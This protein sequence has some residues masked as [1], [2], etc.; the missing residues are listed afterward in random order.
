M[1]AHD[2]G[3]HAGCTRRVVWIDTLPL[4]ALRLSDE[5]VHPAAVDVLH[6]VAR[7]MGAP[8]VHIRRES[9][10]GLTHRL[11]RGSGTQTSGTPSCIRDAI[12]RLDPRPEIVVERTVFLCMITIT[13]LIRC[14][15]CCDLERNPLL[16]VDAL[17]HPVPTNR[18]PMRTVR[19]MVSDTR[20]TRYQGSPGRLQGWRA[21]RGRRRAGDAMPW[22]ISR[23]QSPASVVMAGAEGVDHDVCRRDRRPVSTGARCRGT[24]RHSCA[25]RGGRWVGEFHAPAG[26]GPLRTQLFGSRRSPL[27]T[28]ASGWCW[29]LERPAGS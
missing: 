20:F 2:V 1:I 25:D 13:C 5:P 3:G 28:V 15:S 22:M 18:I 17:E 10:N 19:F 7:A 24:G 4:S 16:S 21:P 11:P 29:V 14:R 6:S 27:R 23:V 9:W 26:G 8:A 12:S